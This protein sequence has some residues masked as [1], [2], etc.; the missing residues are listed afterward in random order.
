MGNRVLI[1]EYREEDIDAIYLHTS[2]SAVVE[3]L[4]W[5]PLNRETAARFV[6]KAIR[7]T[8]DVPRMRFDLAVCLED[9]TILIGGCGL[10]INS[11]VNR[12]GEICYWLSRT[13]WGHGYATE[14]A[15]ALIDVGF[16]DLGLHRIVA[17]CS[18]NNLRSKRVLEKL[19]MRLEGILR[20]DVWQ[21]TRW[22]DS[23]LFSI[24]DVEW[25]AVVGAKE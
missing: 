16:S 20:Q 6:R 13:Y 4:P 2:D 14:T 24:L 8:S 5:G 18:M 15:T 19:Q 9:E 17:T 1:R 25:P 12:E 10:F 11:V 7:E 23:Y 3:H 22:R 21:R